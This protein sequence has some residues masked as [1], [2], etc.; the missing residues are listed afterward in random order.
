MSFRL[1]LTPSINE[2]L[3][4]F[5]EKVLKYFVSKFNDIYGKEFMSLNVH[6]LLHI[7]DDYRRFGS[8]DLCSC[9]PFENFMKTLKKII[10]KHEKPLEQ[11]I[12]RYHELQTYSKLGLKTN[13]CKSVEYLKQ[14]RSGPLPKGCIGPEFKIV[15]KYNLKINVNSSSDNYCK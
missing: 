15:L 12:I 8:L 11:V 1:L 14:H 3:V 5:V 13:S 9:F 4:N 2:E 10:R 7:I 6:N